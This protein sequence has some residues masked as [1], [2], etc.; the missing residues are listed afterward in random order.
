M[1]RSGLEQRER[2]SRAKQERSS[3]ER[4]QTSPLKAA[5][6]TRIERARKAACTVNNP[7]WI[8]TTS[9]KIPPIGTAQR[10]AHFIDSP[11]RAVVNTVGE[12]LKLRF[13]WWLDDPALP[14][15]RPSL[16]VRPDLGQQIPESWHYIDQSDMD[17]RSQISQ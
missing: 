4:A 9:G 5:F 12:M 15:S 1:A 6:A 14:Q 3:P 10:H 11:L 8:A 2:S 13:G 17:V 7:D 16:I